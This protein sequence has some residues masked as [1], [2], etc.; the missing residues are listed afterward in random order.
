MGKQVDTVGEFHGEVSVV[1]ITAF[2]S[3]FGLVT[4]PRIERLIER[5]PYK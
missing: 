4:Q 3:M 5:K 1:R 2:G